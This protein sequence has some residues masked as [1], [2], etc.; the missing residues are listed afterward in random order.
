[1]SE[2]ST[3]PLSDP[4]SISVSLS[5]GSVN[6]AGCVFSN[7]VKIVPALL[8]FGSNSCPGSLMRC[9]WSQHGKRDVE[10]DFDA[11]LFFFELPCARSDILEVLPHRMRGILG[12]LQEGEE[13]SPNAVSAGNNVRIA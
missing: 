2:Y 3:S 5:L 1:M 12:L 10:D 11:R 13:T 8:V 4:K 6:N 9:T 7:S